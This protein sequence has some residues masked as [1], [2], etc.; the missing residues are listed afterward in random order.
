MAKVK[1]TGHASGT[2]VV[3]ITA[4]N[5]STDR[6]ITLP[7]STATIATTGEVVL[8]APLASPSFTGMI[9]FNT[10]T[11]PDT[12]AK[13]HL[14]N[15]NGRIAFQANTGFADSRNWRIGHDDIGPWGSFNI[16]VGPTDN[17]GVATNGTHTALQIT[18][19]G[20]ITKQYQPAFDM[21]NT[22]NYSI[23]ATTDV[24]ATFNAT[25]FDIGNNC[26]TGTD[27]FTAPVAGRYLFTGQVQYSNTSNAHINFIRNGSFIN[28]GWSDMG[29][30]A[31]A[32]QSRIIDLAANDY[33][34]MK[35][36]HGLA[37]TVTGLRTRMTGVLLG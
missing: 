22:G 4:P 5:T 18:K 26:N 31:A 10:T 35:I 19:E 23:A 7:D 14:G 37:A 13:V 17:T 6:T 8:K 24:P 2:G 9:K 3:T 30:T 21:Y 12:R 28:N 32:T 25:E 15:A 16:A 27:R 36:Y 33:V 11:Q 1:I 20:V 34:Q 29:S